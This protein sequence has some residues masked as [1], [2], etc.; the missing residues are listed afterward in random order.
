MK[1]F[2]TAFAIFFLT[3]QAFAQ[4]D[5]TQLVNPFIGTGGHGH[6]Y[7]GASMPFGMMQLSPDTRMDD[8][9][10][11]G[12][13]HY[14]D[15]VIYGFSH[16]HLS[17]TGIP[18]Y[19][20]L[21]LMPF[22]GPVKWKNTEYRSPFSHHTEKASPGYYE[23]RLK[24]GDIL[25]QLTTSVRS[26]MHQYTFPSSATTG[27]LLIDLM[28]RDIVLD[29]ALE[30]VDAYTVRGY[31]RSKSWADN[32][33]FFFYI[34]FD[35]PIRSYTVRHGGREDSSSA[36]QG[37]D[38]Q[39]AL[40]FSLGTGH[41][42][43]CRVGISGVSWDGA[44]A[45]LDGELGK[46]TFAQVQ[47]EA[48]TAWNKEL[49][50]ID[51]SGGTR[52]QQVAFYTALYH[53]NLVPNIYHDLSGDY[54]GTDGKVHN[55]RRY[56]HYSVFSLWDTYRGYHPLM[57]ILNPGRTA[58]WINTFLAQYEE[59][60]MLPVWELS[61]NE[62]FCMI[63]YHSVP[64]IV[65]AW[66]KGI[67]NFDVQLALKAARS[68]AESDRFGLAY[69]RRQGYIANN[70]EHE[71]VSKTLEYAYDD[72]CIAQLARSLGQD[73]V[74]RTYIRRAQHYKNLFDPSTGHMRGKLDA[75]W[76]SPFEPRE[77]NNFYTEGNSWQYSFA[78]PQDIEGLMALHGGRAAFGRKLDALFSAPTQTMGREQPDVTG[79]IGQYAQGN[80]PSHHMAYLYNYIGR[81]QKTQELI[82]RI[83]TEF[84]KNSPDGLIGN[85]DC[86]QMSAW[87]V[88]SALGFYP[89]CPGNSDYV[90]GTP[91]FDKAVIHLEDGKTFTINAKRSA[92]GAFYLQSAQLN[93]KA[94]NYSYILHQRIAAGGSLDL[95]LGT[96]PGLLGTRSGEE[97]RSRIAEYPIAPVPF[98][99][100]ESNRFRDSVLVRI[101][102]PDTTQPVYY[103]VTEGGVQQQR[104]QRYVKPFTLY[105]SSVVHLSETYSETKNLEQEQAFYRIPSNRSITVTSTVNPMYTAGGPDAL[106]DSIF[107]NNNWRSG[108]W[109]SYYGNDFEATVDLKS[110]KPLHY[111]GISVLQ[112]VSPWILYPKEVV[113]EGSDDGIS[114]HEVARVRNEVPNDAQGVQQQRLGTA[115]EAHARYIRIRAVNGGPLPAGHLSAGQPAHL[116]IDEVIVR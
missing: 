65:D 42:L 26:G 30:K 85:E 4:K 110:V 48:K 112:D 33:Q 57:T 20:D 74:Y 12:G 22:S 88:L 97:P 37:K 5:F 63:G 8:W 11:S 111:L 13:Y 70:Q 39:A 51:I 115:V 108:E 24:K 93:G 78:V 94:Y 96:T 14:S 81:P 79:L 87:Y 9:D 44:K 16:T 104:A 98:I 7:P 69:Y 90:F 92:P 52:D 54:R 32:Q 56:T 100:T 61:G 19:C 21:L 91:L 60:G 10:G 73:S 45:N 77:I 67:R 50:K 59:G 80:E 53:S 49:S 102:R 15:S 29:A 47:A 18:D 46:K 64:V 6:T 35:A 71:S 113:F 43:R 84:Y 23:V 55:A 62:T 2:V 114:F 31:R 107:G 1:T 82:H 75:R 38:L 40:R 83:C 95:L 66:Q 105:Q 99:A 76:Y 36:V 68:Y 89:V 72:W 106:L 34:R 28:H 103:Y 3:L 109:Q 116:F 27:G 25:A 17:G 101:E 58:D 41:Q 86:G